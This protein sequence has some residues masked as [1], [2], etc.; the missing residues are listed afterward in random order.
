VLVHLYMALNYLELGQRDEA[1]VE[2]LQ[3]D[4]KLREIAEKFPESKFTED[5]L[6]RYLTG[7]IYEELGEWS[8][9]M[10]AYR[11]AYEAYQKYQS[12]FGV[13]IPS[14]LKLDLVRLAQR[15]GLGDE[16]AQYRKEFGIAPPPKKKAVADDP[17][18]ELVFI[19][20]NGLAPI[21]REKV[22]D[23]WAPPPSS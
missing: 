7:M 12:N 20:N 22:I 14:M 16:L 13:A 5:A 2:A 18:G 4:I 11:K 23:T 1:R 3:V 8:D 10:I 17:Q 6:S 15:Q 9:A 19:L 21:K